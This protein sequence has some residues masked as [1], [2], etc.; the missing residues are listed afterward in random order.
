M[1]ASAVLMLLSA[2]GC[3]HKDPQVSV[4][5]EEIVLSRVQSVD[6]LTLARMRVTKM[7]TIDD[8]RLEDAK[9]PKQV[10]AALMDAVK[11]GDRKAAYSYDTYM[12]AYIDLTEL[13][14]R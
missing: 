4:P 8:L 14:F 5:A 6:R 9:G 11:I 12:S 3:G 1:A 10:V 13:G 7:A 2:V